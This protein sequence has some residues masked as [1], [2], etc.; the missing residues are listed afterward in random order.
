MAHN[1][2][3]M[4]YYGERPWHRLGERLEAAELVVVLDAQAASPSSITTA[5]A[6]A[7]NFFILILHVGF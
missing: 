3:E 2:G 1:I 4:F 6:R 5:R 7:R